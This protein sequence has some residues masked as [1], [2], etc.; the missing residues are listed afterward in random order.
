MKNDSHYER[1]P[2]SF[3]QN[4]AYSYDMTQQSHILAITQMN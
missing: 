1:Q 3:L 2:V 4:S